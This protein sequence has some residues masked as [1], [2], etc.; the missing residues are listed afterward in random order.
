M[1]TI[2]YPH[3]I[4]ILISLIFFFFLHFLTPPCIRF[5]PYFPS[6]QH[7]FTVITLHSTLPHF[8]FHLYP[9]V[10]SFPSL[11]NGIY[12]WAS[13]LVLSPYFSSTNLSKLLAGHYSLLLKQF[14]QPQPQT[15]SSLVLIIF[16][17][18]RELLLLCYAL[19]FYSACLIFIAFCSFCAIR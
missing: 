9:V 17:V 18:P 16:S 19:D 5:T 2:L 4:I 12:E 3:H 6:S 1:S 10:P 14:N 7:S 8:S 11:S 13:V 15:P